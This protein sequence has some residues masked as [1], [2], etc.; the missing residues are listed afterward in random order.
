MNSG[1]ENGALNDYS[2]LGIAL[3]N[4]GDLLN[5]LFDSF[6]ED[7]SGL[8][9]FRGKIERYG[10]STRPILKLSIS[11]PGCGYCSIISMP[12]S[13]MSRLLPASS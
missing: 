4:V 1:E 7:E 13:I 5:R 10:R 12:S 8:I 11:A 9:D 3:S 2:T 6:D